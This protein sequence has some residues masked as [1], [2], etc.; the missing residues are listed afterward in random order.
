MLQVA[1]QRGRQFLLKGA[2]ADIDTENAVL[3]DLTQERAWRIPFQQALKWGYWQEATDANLSDV[4]KLNIQRL[5]TNPES[6]GKP[7][8]LS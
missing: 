8:E 3:V 6:T 7:S 2:K 4:D 5:S 1:A